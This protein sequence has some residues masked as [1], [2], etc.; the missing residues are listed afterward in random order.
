M[1]TFNLLFFLFP[2]LLFGQKTNSLQIF[3]QPFIQ[4][5]GNLN[6][7]YIDVQ[8]EYITVNFAKIPAQEYGLNFQHKRN[9]KW[10]WSLGASYYQQKHEVSIDIQRPLTPA[11][12]IFFHENRKMTFRDLNIKYGVS[13]Q[14]NECLKFNLLMNF[15]IKIIKKPDPINENLFTLSKNII[16]LPDTT[17]VGTVFSSDIK[18]HW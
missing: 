17:Y 5:F 13:Y 3:A 8:N 14:Q 9:S 18:I 10:G 2:T 6:K 7:Q 4:K 1:K 11:T 12:F 15:Q 16:N